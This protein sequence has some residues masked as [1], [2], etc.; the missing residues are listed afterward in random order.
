MC[1]I[2]TLTKLKCITIDFIEAQ[3]STIVLQL[4]V[5]KSNFEAQPSSHKNNKVINMKAKIGKINVKLPLV[6][7]QIN[8]VFM[9]TSRMMAGQL[10][11][12]NS[13]NSFIL[14]SNADIIENPESIPPDSVRDPG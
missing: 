12:F 5:E 9:R 8:K 14:H 10:D 1:Q 11:E 2:L 4:D 13:I 7:D 6:V 3:S